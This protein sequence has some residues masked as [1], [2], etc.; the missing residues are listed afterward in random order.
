MSIV[1]FLAREHALGLFIG[2]CIVLAV[3]GFIQGRNPRSWIRRL[4]S[5]LFPKSSK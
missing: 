1:E 3:L 5:T 2:L 4:A